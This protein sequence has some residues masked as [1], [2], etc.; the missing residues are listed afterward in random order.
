MDPAI[1][2]PSATSAAVLQRLPSAR[3]AVTRRLLVVAVAGVIT[4]LGVGNLLI[5]GLHVWASAASI[6]STGSMSGVQNFH[7]VDDHLW[8][9]GRPTEAGYAALAAAGVK[10]I[11]DLRAESNVTVHE[12]RIGSLGMELVQI[13]IRDGQTP[14]EDQVD[15]FLGTVRNSAG[16]IFVHCMAGVGR[17]GTMVAAYLVEVKGVSPTDAWRHN[18]SVGPPSLEQLAFVSNIDE[19]NIL[20]T[21]LSRVLDAP[22]RLWTYVK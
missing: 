8:R 3:A 16:T 12:D 22:R 5:L 20:V 14:T 4:A 19:P 6:P 13:P 10:T 1:V 2:N 21:A 17:T 18:L 15:R 9:G 7:T 11:V